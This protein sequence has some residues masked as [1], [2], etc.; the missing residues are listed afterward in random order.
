MA[1]LTL[2]ID[3]D[4]LQRARQEALRSKTSVNALVRDFELQ[5][6]TL[7]TGVLA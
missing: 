7:D 3:D 4:L 6:G 1:N 2:V 5:P